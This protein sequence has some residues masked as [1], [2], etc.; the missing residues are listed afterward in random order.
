M[1]PVIID[2]SKLQIQATLVTAQD[3]LQ[4]MGLEMRNRCATVICS[5]RR[6]SQCLASP[7]PHA[8]GNQS[9]LLSNNL[10]F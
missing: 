2:V 6:V 10:S 4:M 7:A 8:E 1:S 3:R 9:G 5:C